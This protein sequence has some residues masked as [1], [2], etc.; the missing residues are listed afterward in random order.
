MVETEITDNILIQNILRGDVESE[1]ILYKKYKKIITSNIKK[2]CSKNNYVDDDVSEIMMKIFSSLN[3]F[4]PQKSKFSTWVYNICKNFLINKNKK[5]TNNNLINNNT[6]NVDLTYSIQNT[7]ELSH[8]QTSCS[9]DNLNMI[10]FLKN[11]ISHTDFNYL[12]LHYNQGYSY[13][14]IGKEYN[15]SSETIS[16]RVNY[17]KT[18]LKKEVNFEF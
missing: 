4:D 1:N 2:K 14:E 10:E 16:N 6:I 17:V 13:C 11:K 18:K 15:L 5:E 8:N 7:F 3:S 12:D 9:Y